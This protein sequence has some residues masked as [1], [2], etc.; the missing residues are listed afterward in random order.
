LR[1]AAEE[2]LFTSWI[3]P[4][5][6]GSSGAKTLFSARLCLQFWHFFFLILTLFKT[7][8]GPFSKTA[9]YAWNARFHQTVRRS[10][11]YTDQKKVMQVFPRIF[12]G[13]ST[14]YFDRKRGRDLVIG[15]Y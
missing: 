2:V 12:A 5:F 6:A 13:I 3:A 8:L 7:N 9:R 11:V 4:D 14:G 1:T 15:R 10:A